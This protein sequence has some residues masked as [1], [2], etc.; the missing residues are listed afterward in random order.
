[1]KKKRCVLFDFDG[2][3]FNSIP[4]SY[5]ATCRVFENAGCLTPSFKDFWL[6]CHAPFVD[7]YR[8]RG[9]TLLEQEIWE[10]FFRYANFDEVRFFDDVQPTTTRLAEEDCFLG[11]VSGQQTH[12][13]RKYCEQGDF[14]R[15]FSAGIVGDVVDKAF[16]IVQMCET[17]QIPLELVW[18]VGDFPSDMRA[19]KKASV[20]AVGITRGFSV[21]DELKVSGAHHVI[22]NLN[23]LLP[24][25][26]S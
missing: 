13:I 19:A 26:L 8:K 9:V 7:F 11:I 2:T 21:H 3:I 12:L 5:R 23:D 15:V 22:D 20:L 6:N 4:R 24:L 16:A 1:M 18:Y 25:V 14:L 10:I 17:M